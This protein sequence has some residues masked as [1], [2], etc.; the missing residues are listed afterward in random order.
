ME[1]AIEPTP[2]AVE[3]VTTDDQ[4]SLTL[5]K[6][7]LKKR[8]QREKWL[9]NKDERRKYEKEKRKLKR[10]MQAKQREEHGD[11][12]VK[13]PCRT[14]MAESK[15]KFRVV[16]DMDFEDYMTEIE[17]SKAVLQV[18]RIYAINRHSENPCQ[19]YISSLKGKI[20]DRFATTNAGYLN[21]DINHSEQDYIS[22]F[23]KE[24]DS[25]NKNK[26]VYL[27]GDAE[28]NLPDVDDILKDE[29]RIF[30]IGG[31]VDH[32]RHKNLCHNMARERKITTAKLPIKDHLTLNQRD[33]L[34]TVT[35]FEIM[36]Q[37]LGFH[38][39]WPEALVNSIP[40]RKV[41]AV[42]PRVAKSDAVDVSKPV[43]DKSDDCIDNDSHT[44][45]VPEAIK[46]EI[47]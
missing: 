29:S 33:I 40:K 18:G 2:Q 44:K 22:L 4:V 35:V 26:F 45:D 1:Q 38:K 37:V 24:E 20:R 12:I 15:N 41:A 17:I 10:Q 39:S 6:S 30:V 7:Q 14:L 23:S 32:N 46:D 8:L 9:A 47:R 11:Q 3:D 36:L 13:K 27:S 31:L 28:E 19:L 25:N 34:S 16:T 21:W 42:K 5:S 43:N